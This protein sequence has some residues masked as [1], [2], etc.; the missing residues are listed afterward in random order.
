M[1]IHPYKTDPICNFVKLTRHPLALNLQLLCSCGQIL[2]SR[3][4]KCHP[5][6]THQQ[7]DKGHHLRLQKEMQAG[8]RR[9][10]EGTLTALGWKWLLRHTWASKV[11]V[12]Q[13]QTGNFPVG[14]KA[15]HEVTCHIKTHSMHHGT[16]KPCGS[17]KPSPVLMAGVTDTESQG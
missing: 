16:C 9:K 7:Y 6:G 2:S 3:S 11:W 4:I 8:L 12:T 10:Q 1:P 15:T 14:S 5:R 17:L 13:R